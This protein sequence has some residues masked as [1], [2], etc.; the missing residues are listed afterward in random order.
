MSINI[1]LDAPALTKLIEGDPDF[2]LELQRAVIAEITRKLYLNDVTGDMQKLIAG[3]FQGHKDD[4]VRAVKEDDATRKFIDERLSALVQSVRSGSFGYV[5][6]KKLSDELKGMVNVHV[7]NLIQEECERQLGKI[8]KL[9]EAKTKEIEEE[10]LRRIGKLAGWVEHNTK[11]EMLKQ[12]REDVA[13][14]ITE[15]F[16]SKA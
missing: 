6:Q 2:K 8:P 14:T 15:Q 3:A 12:I 5:S 9:I 13:R 1:K 11:V 7:A 4:L 16:G 10:V